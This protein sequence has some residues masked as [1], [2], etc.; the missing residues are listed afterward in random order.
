MLVGLA[1]SNHREATLRRLFILLLVLFAYVLPNPASVQA[2]ESEWK[3]QRTQR[4]AI[5]YIGGY[6]DTAQQYAGFVDSIYDE[7]AA[8][9]GH[10]TATP[11]KLRLYPTI[12]RY[13]QVNPLARSMPGIVAHADARRREVAVILAQTSAQTDVEIQNNIRHELAH[14]I[15]SELSG[16]RLAI[17]FQEGLAQY[18]ELPARELEVRIEY[19]RAS[20]RQGRLMPWSAL[21][22]REL[23]YANPDVSYPQSL[24][25]VAFLIERYSFAAMRDFITVNATSTGYRDAL[26][27]AFEATPDEL[28]SEW[29]AWL[30]SYLEGG[31]RRN[32]LT[33]YDLSRA[34]NLLRMG[35]YADAKTELEDAIAWLRTTT[36]TDV[37][38][39][40]RK[41][42]ERSQEGQK[43]EELANQAR[44]ALEQADYALAAQLVNQARQH[45]AEIGDT[46]QEA[47][48]R[49]YAER[50]ERGM[51]AVATLDQAQALMSALR[52]PQAREVADRAV[53][54]FM[55]LGDQ[56]RMSQALELRS[57][58][59]QR[60][61]LLGMLLLIFGLGGV[62][63]TVVRRFTTQDL[64]VW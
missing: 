3:E 39:E 32:A 27:S 30:P 41:L 51:N 26:E 48:L 31:Y 25:V 45:Y 35:R 1:Q 63:A 61:T 34:E 11:I 64:E 47:V 52:Y 12:E 57:F 16:D 5:L 24:S 62:C 50:A 60:Q 29:F 59:D 42:L 56:M 49:V 36:Q 8:L 21:M 20:V 6:E 43:A 22:D 55:S 54:E 17:G 53:A 18:V 46:R 4:F 9:F 58:L 14:I 7:M 2:Q 23:M 40:A 13:Q 37:L 10:R 44:N 28:E 19:L 15:A 38:A 33:A